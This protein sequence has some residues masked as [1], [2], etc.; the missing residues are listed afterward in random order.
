MG[1]ETAGGFPLVWLKVGLFILRALWVSSDT[2]LSFPVQPGGQDFCRA[3]MRDEQSG[4]ELA[5]KFDLTKTF[6]IHE[7]RVKR[8]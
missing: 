7:W 6:E 3:E 1:S 4:L 5:V 2:L 8:T